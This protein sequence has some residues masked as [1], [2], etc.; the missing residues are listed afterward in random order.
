MLRCVF[1]AVVLWALPGLAEERASRPRVS[2]NHDF[3]VRMVVQGPGQ[4]VLEVSSDS[5]PVWSLK[6]CVGTVDDLY[7][8]SNDGERVWVL[9][10]IV[11]KGTVKLPGKQNKKIPAW[12]NTGVAVEFDRQGS[13]YREKRL[14]DFVEPYLLP[15]VVQMSQHVKWLEGM[16]GVPGKSPR[17]TDAGNLEFET[18]GGGKTHQLKF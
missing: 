10:P 1:L 2:A 15:K 18:V 7:F 5:G 4:C 17:L 9:Y 8:V 16:L 12:A 13:R 14:L 3:T 6:Q 11:P